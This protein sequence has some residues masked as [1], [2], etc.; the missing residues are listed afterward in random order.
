MVIP[1]WSTQCFPTSSQLNWQPESFVLYLLLGTQ[2]MEIRLGPKAPA[3]FSALGSTGDR[4]CFGSQD[5]LQLL[6]VGDCKRLASSNIGGCYEHGFSLILATG[7]GCAILHTDATVHMDQVLGIEKEMEPALLLSS[8]LGQ[9]ATPAPWAPGGFSMQPLLF[10][11]WQRCGPSSAEDSCSVIIL[12]H[13]QHFPEKH[14]WEMGNSNLAQ[15]ITQ[16]ER[17]GVSWEK[18]KACL[19]SQNFHPCQ[20]SKALFSNNGDIAASLKNK[21][22]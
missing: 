13:C 19:Q 2:K 8:S 22:Q 9:A 12:S 14:K 7:S 15:L 6:L 1:Q 18:G 11:L 4:Q 3:F 5:L 10:L 20:N 21:I 17:R 16:P